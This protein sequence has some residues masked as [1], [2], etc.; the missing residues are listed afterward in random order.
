MNGVKIKYLVTSE[1]RGG[2]EEKRGVK[3]RACPKK[4]RGLNDMI[5]LLG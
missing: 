2:G 5:W 1:E 4:G 3:K